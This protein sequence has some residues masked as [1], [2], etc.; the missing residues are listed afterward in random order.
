MLVVLREIVFINVCCMNYLGVNNILL[1]GNFYNEE[2]YKY[3]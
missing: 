3:F 2:F 1:N